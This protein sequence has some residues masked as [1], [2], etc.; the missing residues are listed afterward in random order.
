MRESRAAVVYNPVKIRLDRVRRAVQEQELANG[1]GES[2]WYETSREDSGTRAAREALAAEPT[3]LIVAG[4]DGTIRAVAEAIYETTTPVSLLPTGTGN[5]LARN[6]H[7]PL[8]DIDGAVTA[9]FGLV[10]RARITV[11]PG[12]LR[13]RIGRLRHS[14]Q[15]PSV[16]EV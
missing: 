11:H 7:L 4:G 13:V 15:G 12:A 16:R 5:L 2:R 6:L 10:A 1:W 9:A 8:N 14:G 3:V